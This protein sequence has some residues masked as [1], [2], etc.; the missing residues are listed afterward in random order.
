M[1]V[2]MSICLFVH[3]SSL[4][5]PCIVSVGRDPLVAVS[6]YRHWSDS[7][8]WGDLFAPD[9]IIIT[10]EPDGKFSSGFSGPLIV[11]LLT[12]TNKV[13]WKKYLE[14]WLVSL[15]NIIKSHLY[16]HANSLKSSKY[17]SSYLIFHRHFCLQFLCQLG[18]S[19]RVK[20]VNCGEKCFLCVIAFIM[21]N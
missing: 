14:N 3:L 11:L 10:T 20:P 6:H 17:T 8:H 18:T 2:W 19:D 12:H 15:W 1:S 4:L 13:P 7:V 9:S 21:Y 16:F 5:A